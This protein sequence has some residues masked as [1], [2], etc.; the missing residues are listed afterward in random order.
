MLVRMAGIWGV[1]LFFSFDCVNLASVPGTP[2]S[3]LT[4]TSP[5]ASIHHFTNM[6]TFP[7]LITVCHNTESKHIKPRCLGGPEKLEV[8]AFG[9]K[10]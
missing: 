7:E 10:R 1:V 5:S 2:R 3:D 9:K 8:E 6:P 4:N